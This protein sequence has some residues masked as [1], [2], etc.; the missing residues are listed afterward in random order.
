MFGKIYRKI[1][2][3]FYDTGVSKILLVKKVHTTILKHTAP[4]FITVFGYKMFLDQFDISKLS[5]LLDHETER[6]K[7]LKKLVKEGDTVIVVGANIGFFPLFFRSIVG[8]TGRVISFEPEPRNFALLKKN[9]IANKFENVDIYQKAVG[10]K[11][12]KVK[13]LLSDSIGEHHISN[14]GDIEI[15]CI[16]LDDYVSSANFIKL[17]AEGYEIEILKGMPNLLHQ[18][19]ILMSEFYIKLLNNYSNPV[20]FFNILK[21]DDFSFR[22]MRNNMHPI[23]ESNFM[24]NYDENSGATDILCTKNS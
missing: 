22:D 4:E 8:K 6:I 18:K 19:T 24:L 7:I 5:V 15:D 1:S 12:S 10:S 2:K 21:K 3:L 11:N 13:M 16:R 23:N 17:D 20:E 14:I 9:I